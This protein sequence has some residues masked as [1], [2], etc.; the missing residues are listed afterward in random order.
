MSHLKFA[1]GSVLEI[2]GAWAGKVIAHCEA[3]STLDDLPPVPGFTP[4]QLPTLRSFLRAE[5]VE[6]VALLS[7][8]P[9]PQADRV[10]FA[11]LEDPAGNWRDLRGQPLKITIVSNPLPDDVDPK[12]ILADPVLAGHR[13]VVLRGGFVQCLD[14]GATWMAKVGALKRI[15]DE[16]RT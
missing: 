3:L 2:D 6:R 7:Y 11:A 16:V 13:P 8:A 14:C 1:V 9:G 4:D 10:C 12:S 5:H 15:D